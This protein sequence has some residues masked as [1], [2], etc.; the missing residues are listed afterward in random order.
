MACALENGWLYH[1]FWEMCY[2]G[3]I[4]NRKITKPPLQHF[5]CYVL[6]IKY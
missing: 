6:C 3:I 1:L 5:N 4:S 2:D